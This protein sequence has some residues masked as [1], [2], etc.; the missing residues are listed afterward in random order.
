M[1]AGHGATSAA[2]VDAA[3]SP[4]LAG[5]AADGVHK[6]NRIGNPA[7]TTLHLAWARSPDA[8]R[9]RANTMRHAFPG[10]SMDPHV[11]VLF[12]AAGD[13]SRRNLLPGLFRLSQA[14]R[15][16]D[17]RLVGTSLEDLSDDG[18]RQFAR[19]A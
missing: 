14:N 8:A 7:E 12:G 17:Y 10:G 2:C 13:L 9:S 1:P 19:E 4:G 11:I 16:P 18:F 15:L 3:L 5:V 6:K